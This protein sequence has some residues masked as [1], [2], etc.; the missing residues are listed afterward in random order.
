MKMMMR[1][2]MTMVKKTTTMIMRVRMSKA[3]NMMT[4]KRMSMM[5]RMMTRMVMR[6]MSMA[7]SMRTKTMLM[8][9]VLIILPA[10]ASAEDTIPDQLAT[11]AQTNLT[12]QLPMMVCKPDPSATTG[13]RSDPLSFTWPKLP[14]VMQS[15]V[16]SMIHS[17]KADGASLLAII[18]PT[19][20]EAAV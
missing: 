12:H 13:I 14:S 16:A 2:R 8:P 17:S 19:P 9:V 7:M 5:M 18:M 3:M 20:W 6:M 11:S 4:R 1:A 10:L 15:S